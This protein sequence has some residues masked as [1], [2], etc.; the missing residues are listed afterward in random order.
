MPPRFAHKKSLLAALFD[1]EALV[2]LADENW[3]AF[4]EIGAQMDILAARREGGRLGLPFRL[5]I[6]P[7]SFPEASKRGVY[8][9]LGIIGLLSDLSGNEVV[10]LREIFQVRLGA[11]QVRQGRG[12]IYTNKLFAPPGQYKLLASLS[13]RSPLGGS[14]LFLPWCELARPG[15]A[16]GPIHSLLQETQPFS[17]GNTG[18]EHRRADL[19]DRRGKGSGNPKAIP[20]IQ[21]AKMLRLNVERQNG[22]PHLLGQPYGSGLHSVARAP[23]S[24]RGEGQH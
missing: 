12:I 11:K 8:T 16:A 24:I 17:T 6:N 20:R 3:R 4:R 5:K 22:Q 18:Q 7:L 9:Q 10:R 15:S 19:D 1:H 14:L 2:K 13:W 23:G 21:F